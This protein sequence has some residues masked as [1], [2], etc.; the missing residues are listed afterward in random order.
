LIVVA[1]GRGGVAECRP[2]PAG[3]ASTWPVVEANARLMATAPDLLAAARFALEEMRHVDAPR[4]SFTAAVEALDAA[5]T[6]A[7]RR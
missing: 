1:V 2:I 3:H 7:T 4:Q 6:K 5:I